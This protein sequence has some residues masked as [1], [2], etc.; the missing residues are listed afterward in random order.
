MAKGQH[1][2]RHQQKI[3]H[4][5]YEHRDTIVTQRLGEIVTELYLCETKKKADNLWDRA[6]KSLRQSEANP[7]R[8][9]KVLADRDIK[10]LAE[11]VNELAGA[12]EAKDKRG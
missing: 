5:Y 4:R 1:Y 9:E 3:I 8:V 12:P 11:L 2:S 7:A 10:K 6:A